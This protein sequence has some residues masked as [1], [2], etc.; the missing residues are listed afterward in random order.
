LYSILLLPEVASVV[1]LP[2]SLFSP[3]NLKTCNNAP[4]LISIFAVPL[5]LPVNVTVLAVV[6]PKLKLPSFI[7]NQPAIFKVLNADVPSVSVKVE[8][9]LLTATLFNV[10][11]AF[12]VIVA[13]LFSSKYKVPV[14]EIPAPPYFIKLPFKVKFPKV[15]VFEFYCQGKVL[16]M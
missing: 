14:W 13:L 16:E 6:I 2:S 3:F 1:K 11:V 4:P 10:M 15:L 8:D 5:K 9:V 12:E 7:S